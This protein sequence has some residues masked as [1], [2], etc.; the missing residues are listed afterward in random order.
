M[1]LPKR[2]RV[3][4]SPEFKAMLVAQCQEPGASIA[5][6]AMAHQI[7][8]NMLRT[9]LRKSL[10]A[11]LP[12]TRAETIPT[13]PRLVPLQL[14]APVESMQ[15]VRIHIQHGNT[16]LHIEWPVADAARCGQWLQSWLR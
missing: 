13:S 16:Q 12:A 15:S 7:N 3:K 4:R 5:A 1:T 2:R 8:D 6:V 9:W 10:D 11:G 14:A